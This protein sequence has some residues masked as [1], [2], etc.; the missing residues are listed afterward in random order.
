[1]WYGAINNTPGRVGPPIDKPNPDIRQYFLEWLDGDGTPFWSFW[2][3]IASWWAVRT[4]PNVKALHYED[5]KR[6]LPGTMRSIA[7]FLDTPI[8]E[9]TFPAQV[10]HCTFAWMK[11]HASQTAP[12][13]GA[14]WDG[15]GE[16]FINKGING[17]WRDILTADDNRRYEAM[18][19]E[20]LGPECAA[21]LKGG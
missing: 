18:A 3:N 15:G 11:A 6:D 17:R 21:W 5:L 14:M 20:K 2:D 1:M 4:L 9:T 8:D 13:G 19:I 7:T 10:E 12:L 16:T